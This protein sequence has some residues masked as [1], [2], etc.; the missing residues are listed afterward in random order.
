MDITPLYNVEGRA[1]AY[2]YEG[3]YIY[4]YGGKPVA[5]FHDE[6]VYGFD[7]TYLGWIQ[8]GWIFDRHGCGAFFTKEATGGPA[9]RRYGFGA[10]QP[11][12]WRSRNCA[13]TTFS[14]VIPDLGNNMSQYLV[15]RVEHAP[16]VDVCLNTEATQLHGDDRLE[17]ITVT[18]HATGSSKDVAAHGLFV[19][20]GAHPC[21]GWLKG[22]VALD[23]K[24]FVRAGKGT[25]TPFATSAVGDVRSG[26]VKRVASA[27][28][29][30][31]VVVQDVH[32]YL[33]SLREPM[34]N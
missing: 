5:F 33:A 28:G 8:N 14:A 9:M 31:S 18:N 4:L 17:S 29:E 12:G 7:G 25:D 3:K 23:D 24:G 30:G 19:M 6:H 2:V 27:V 21:A 13:G 16:N 11:C 26:S 22:S 1:V 10:F 32:H 15:D 20:I 34:T